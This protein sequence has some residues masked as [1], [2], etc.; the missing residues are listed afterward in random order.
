MRK[1]IGK[2][3]FYIGMSRR[4]Q[5]LGF[6]ISFNNAIVYKEFVMVE[7]NLLWVK[8]WYTFDY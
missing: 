8:A 4:F 6:L 7:L 2:H 5:G 1:D 3:K